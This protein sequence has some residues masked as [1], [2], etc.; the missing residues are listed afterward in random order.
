LI[1][2]SR[3]VHAARPM[4]A[5]RAPRS[6]CLLVCLAAAL[7]R[8]AGADPTDETQRWVPSFGLTSGVFA[9]KADASA[10]STGLTYNF[11]LRQ[12]SFGQEVDTVTQITDANLRPPVDGD[13]ILVTPFVGGTF[14]LDTPGVQA[15]PGRPRLF[16]RGDIA[17]AF[18]TERKVAREKTPSGL[19]DPLPDQPYF[20][21]EAVPGI[22]SETTAEV[23]PLTYSAGAGVAFTIDIGSRRL[24]IKPSIEYIHEQI[25]F[26]GAVIR[27][28]NTDTGIVAQ[29]S[30]TAKPSV[31]FGVTLQKDEKQDFQGLGP[32]L[33]I[34]MDTARIGPFMLSLFTNGRGMKVLGDRKVEWSDSTTVT[35]PA[36]IP[37]TTTFDANWEFEK[38][39]WIFG[40]GVG[41]RF[42]WVPK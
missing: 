27:A 18:G 23:Q 11:I 4:H 12:N 37:N 9:Q 13:D 34:E 33:E 42:R 1:D 16:V 32:G 29:Q 22:G 17:G 19:P 21:E 26:T 2:A 30:I 35:D 10:T 28:V 31:F 14:E 6:A 40:G 36:M 25:D 24:R 15:W 3:L 20:A 5:R 39:P 38:K 7:A 41:I 8:P